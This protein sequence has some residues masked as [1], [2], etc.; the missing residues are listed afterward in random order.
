MAVRGASAFHAHKREH[1]VL[2]VW[3]IGPGRRL[4]AVL[5][6]FTRGA[7]VLV[8]APPKAASAVSTS[9]PALRKDN[10][11]HQHQYNDCKSELFHRLCSCKLT[12]SLPCGET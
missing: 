6:D 2:E 7:I 4:V 11:G 1:I 9:E 5:G 3:R 10:S 12:I 8:V